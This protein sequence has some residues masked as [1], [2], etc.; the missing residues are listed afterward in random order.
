M[1][2]IV[3]LKFTVCVYADAT[4]EKLR[5]AKVSGR[6]PD[7]RQTQEASAHSKMTNQRKIM[8][9]HG[10]CLWIK[11][12]NASARWKMRMERKT[13]GCCMMCWMASWCA[14]PFLQ[15]IARIRGTVTRRS[16]NCSLFIYDQQARTHCQYTSSLDLTVGAKSG[17]ALKN[18]RTTR[19]LI[20][21]AQSALCA[22]K[23]AIT[24]QKTSALYS[25]QTHC[26][27]RLVGCYLD[28]RWSNLR[29]SNFKPL[30]EP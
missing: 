7:R 20:Q 1:E 19:S 13:S 29:E 15:R 8:Q 30:P 6:P 18:R 25:W 5:G 17:R 11:S 23:T 10:R 3:C 2:C 16:R 22:A 21:Q 28:F 14:L 9:S 27:C 12:R 4:A 26:H 24:R